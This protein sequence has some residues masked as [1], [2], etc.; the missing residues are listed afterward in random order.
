MKDPR[1]H[2]DHVRERWEGYGCWT[3]P[4]GEEDVFTYETDASD[5]RTG[6]AHL[7]ARI[8]FPGQPDAYLHVEEW[9]RPRKGH[10]EREYY[11]YDL[12]YKGGRLDNWHR[13]E[14]WD[15]KHDD[16]RQRKDPYRRVTLEEALEACWRILY[17]EKV[18]PAE[19]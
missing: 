7:Q 14:G 13:H 8:F 2:F 1:E 15:H 10:L 12:I 17:E 11:S 4:V 16:T 3:E 19:D 18:P 9:I 6:R 5:A